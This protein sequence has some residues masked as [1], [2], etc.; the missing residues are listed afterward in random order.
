MIVTLSNG[1]LSTSLLS[2][3]GNNNCE[4]RTFY[5]FESPNSKQHTLVFSA[6]PPIATKTV[7]FF[8][9]ACSGSCLR[10]LHVH[11]GPLAIL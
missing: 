9:Y 11:C 7:T 5:T 1:M 3:S 6:F 8:T 4:S 2:M 10:Q